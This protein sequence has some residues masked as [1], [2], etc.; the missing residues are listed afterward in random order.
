MRGSQHEV[1]VIYIP[2]KGFPFQTS[3]PRA[4]DSLY[5]SDP[6]CNGLNQAYYAQ[7]GAL[8]FCKEVAL[9]KARF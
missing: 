1:R 4:Q 9:G 2:D 6:S 5:T 8:C 3:N 7:E